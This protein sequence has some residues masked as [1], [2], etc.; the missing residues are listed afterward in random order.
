MA[1]KKQ[2][3]SGDSVL[4]SVAKTLGTAAGNIASAVGVTKPK[5][6]GKTSKLAKKHKSRL[7]RRQKKSLGK[8]AQVDKAGQ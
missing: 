3:E 4:V 6:S 7:P 1:K 8:A 5:K 2:E